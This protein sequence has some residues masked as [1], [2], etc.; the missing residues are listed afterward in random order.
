VRVRVRLGLVLGAV[1]LA[2]CAGPAAT[3][4]AGPHSPTPAP[5]SPALP[6]PATLPA[7]ETPPP[8]PTPAAGEVEEPVQAPADP[9]LSSAIQPVLEEWHAAR[10]VPGA[11]LGIRLADGRS[12]VVAIGSTDD[13][14]GQ[15]IDPGHRFR[16]GS[17]TK[18]FVAVLIMQLVADGLVELDATVSEYLP[19]MPFADEV[20]VRQLLAHRSGIPDF[21]A[22]TGYAQLLLLE[23]GRRW[24]AEEVVSLVADL[25]LRFEPG[26]SMSYSNT[27]YS[28]A[29]LIA[30]EVTGEPLADLIRSRISQPGGLAATYLEELEPAPQMAVSG[31]FDINFDGEPDNV[32][33]VP[34]T[35]LVTSGAAAGGMSAPAGDLLEFGNALFGGELLDPDSLA[36]MTAGTDGSYRLGIIRTTRSGRTVLGHDGALPGFSAAFGHLPEAG[37]TVVAMANQTGANVHAL[38]ES[39]LAAL[40]DA[41]EGTP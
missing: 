22:Q 23:P 32:R 25:P 20:T 9:A 41:G 14:G 2:A 24:T 4:P 16:I 26:S 31:H 7:G 10:D 18:T 6:P 28:I 12:A 38:V 3:T 15:P 39:A 40:A 36:E 8:E 29:G 1:L 30:E 19:E 33:G 34:Y 17:V 11:V 35:A 13:E 27:N 21:G 5:P 37:V